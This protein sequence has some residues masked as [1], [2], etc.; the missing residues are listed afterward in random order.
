M[1]QKKNGM[2]KMTLVRSVTNIGLFGQVSETGIFELLSMKNFDR[3]YGLFSHHCRDIS[4]G[5]TSLKYW[6]ALKKFWKLLKL[7]FGCL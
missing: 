1:Q 2:F 3:F 7:T 5:E 4:L 6:F